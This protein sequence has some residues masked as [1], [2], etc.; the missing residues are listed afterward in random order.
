VLRR[1]EVLGLEVDD[2]SFDRKTV[3]FRENAWRRL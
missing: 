3:T 2:V 1:A